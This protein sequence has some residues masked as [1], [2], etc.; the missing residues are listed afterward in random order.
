[1]NE[2][3]VLFIWVANK[4]HL[5]AMASTNRKWPIQGGKIVFKNKFDPF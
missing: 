4:A 3:M 1:M 2:R 5:E